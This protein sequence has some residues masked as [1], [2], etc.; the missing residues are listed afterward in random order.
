MAIYNRNHWNPEWE[1]IP[2]D[3]NGP[4]VDEQEKG[5]KARALKPLIWWKV[6]WRDFPAEGIF[7]HDRDWFASHDIAFVTTFDGED[8]VLIDRVWFGWPDPP[9]WGLASR[10]QGRSDVR[11]KMWGSFPDLPDAWLVPESS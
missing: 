3:A 1:P 11:W 10:P 4:E 9:R 6:D 7:G 5:F 2:W 8:L